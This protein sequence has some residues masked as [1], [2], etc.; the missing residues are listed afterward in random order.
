M[1]SSPPLEDLP[2]EDL[3]LEE[4]D[5]ATGEAVRWGGG[6]LTSGWARRAGAVSVRS[7]E[8]FEGTSL[9]LPHYTILYRYTLMCRATGARMLARGTLAA[10]CSSIST[11]Y[12]FINM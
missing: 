5:P 9:W 11:V 12:T 1:T 4:E 8:G 6:V 3:P 2:L 7:C 10:W